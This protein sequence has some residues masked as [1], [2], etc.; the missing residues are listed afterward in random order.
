MKNRAG[1][2]VPGI[3]LILLGAFFLLRRLAPDVF[4]FGW[5]NIWPVFPTLVG[6]GSLA[7]WLFSE[8]RDPGLL[9]L[10][11]AATLVG[12]FFFLFSFG[13]FEWAE[14]GKLWPAFPI[15]GGLAFLALFV[16][17]RFRDWGAAG[18]GCM[19]IAVGVIAFGF[20]LLHLPR[21]LANQLIKLWP[22][23]LIFIGLLALVS[24]FVRRSGS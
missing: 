8:E 9:F 21:P 22:L 16:G 23:G 17:G 1:A 6:V 11:T 2:I 12:L 3:I 4:V 18:V 7:G 13:L 20:T 24:A 15:I 5:G 19:A 10:G 14:M